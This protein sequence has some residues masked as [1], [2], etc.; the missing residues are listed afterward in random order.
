MENI[1][2]GLIR[3]E[4]RFVAKGL[5][6]SLVS[7]GFLLSPQAW[8]LNILAN[9]CTKSEARIAALGAP[10]DDSQGAGEANS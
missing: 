10:P 1:K 5:R 3:R 2:R 8:A 4:T 7:K 9:Q 6:E